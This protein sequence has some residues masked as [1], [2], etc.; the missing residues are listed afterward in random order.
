MCRAI[1]VAYKVDEVKEMM[2][3]ATAIEVYAHQSQNIE[4]ERQACEIRMRATRRLG[5]LL[6]EREKAKGGRPPETPAVTEGVKPL[7]DLG[8]THKQS[9]RYQKLAEVPEDDFEA[10]LTAPG[11][12]AGAADSQCRGRS[13]VVAMGAAQGLRTRGVVGR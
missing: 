4:A 12:R 9:H 10:A 7:A 6:A 3:Q 13:R 5:Q 2:D 1:A 8:I 11:R